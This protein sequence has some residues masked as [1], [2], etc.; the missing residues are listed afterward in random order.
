MSSMDIISLP[1][2]RSKV[3]YIIP[4]ADTLAQQEEPILNIIEGII[5]S[6]TWKIKFF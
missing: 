4:I 1:S 3:Y 6:Y 5:I 2:I